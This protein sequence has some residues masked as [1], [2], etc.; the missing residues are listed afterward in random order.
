M[1]ITQISK[2][3]LILSL[4]HVLIIGGCSNKQDKLIRVRDREDS[5]R[6]FQIE[7][8]LQINSINLNGE[9]RLIHKL[10]GFAGH[11]VEPEGDIRIIFYEDSVKYKNNGKV[12]AR[13]IWTIEYSSMSVCDDCPILMSPIVNRILF[14]SLT[15]SKLI[16]M[17]DLFDGYEYIYR[18]VK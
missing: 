14:K 10:G 8:N 2:C 6:L 16:L 15:K 1:R 18:R 7:R 5:R 11:L 3:I 12:T 4:I 13:D 9:W 17:D